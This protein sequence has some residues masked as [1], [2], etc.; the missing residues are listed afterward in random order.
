MPILMLT[1]RQDEVD[2]IAGLELGADDYVAKPFSLGE[3]IARV[4][5]IMCR[6]IANRPAAARCWMPARCGWTQARG[7]LGARAPS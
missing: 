5:A 2:R 6:S 4:R 3:L 7:A 1:A